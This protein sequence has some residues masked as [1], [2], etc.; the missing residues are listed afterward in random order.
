MGIRDLVLRVIA[1]NKILHD[2]PTLEQA[3]GSPVREGVRQS[4]D[5]P[6]GVD[7]QEPRLLCFD[8]NSPTP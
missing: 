8:V 4:R 7:L 3:D 2:G 1:I 6:I 5:T